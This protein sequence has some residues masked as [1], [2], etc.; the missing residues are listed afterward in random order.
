LLEG[1]FPNYRQLIPASY[2]NRLTVGREALL[3]AVK[4]VKLLIQEP[5]TPVRLTMRSEGVE[6]AVITSDL[7]RAHEEVDAK[8]EGTELV[9]AFNPDYLIEGVE[10]I[11]GDE[12]VIESTDA[13][14][15]ATVRSTEAD[16]FMYLLM[17]VRVT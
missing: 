7:G 14:K 5:T 11:S 17:P 9:V 6:V 16:D 8:Y 2:P 1:E 4:R 13:L 15:P 12:V 10:A 3:D